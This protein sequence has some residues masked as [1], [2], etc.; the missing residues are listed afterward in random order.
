MLNLPTELTLKILSYLPFNSLSRL[1]S[2]CK[3]WS[4]FCSLHENT[5]YRNAACLHTYIPSP[6]M[7]LNELG[8]FYSKRALEDVETWKDLCT[9]SIE[10]HWTGVSIST[11]T[12]KV[13]GRKRIQIQR[14]WKGKG[15]STLAE[16]K[17]TSQW[18]FIVH[19]I[20]VDELAGYI[21]MTFDKGGLLVTALNEDY[22]LWSLPEVYNKFLSLPF[23]CY[24]TPHIIGVCPSICSSWVW[25][26]IYDL[27]PS[28]WRQGSLE[29]LICYFGTCRRRIL[30]PWCDSA[31]GIWFT[32]PREGWLFPTMGCITYAWTDQCISLRLPYPPCRCLWSRLPLG[33]S[34]WQTNSNNRRLPV[35]RFGRRQQPYVAW[36][37]VRWN[38]R[39]ACFHRWPIPSASFFSSNWKERIELLIIG[40][41]R[42][43]AL[44]VHTDDRTWPNSWFSV[45]QIRDRVNTGTV[46]I[47]KWEKRYKW[48]LC[49]WYVAMLVKIK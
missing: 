11:I 33:R 22:I 32:D 35:Y 9:C 30:C 8:S 18:S 26:R 36:N 31:W 38:Q 1:Q 3:S 16:H 14:N 44:E 39:E 7:M 42:V 27:W 21:M 28:Q 2:V 20:K 45:G 5:I 15:P 43:W 24:S 34:L 13:S 40:S 47:K 29:V 46:W 25:A 17:S 49:C 41:R 19:R 23:N 6:T 12:D 4:E 48:D 10:L 37:H